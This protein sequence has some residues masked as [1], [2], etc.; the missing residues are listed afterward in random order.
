MG[1]YLDERCA[2]LRIPPL[3]Y[4]NAFLQVR[5]KLRHEVRLDREQDHLARARAF[6]ADEPRVHVPALLPHCT[7][8][9]TAMERLTG[10]LRKT[11]SNAAFLQDLP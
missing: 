1:A 7:P 4:A 6:Y 2:D 11:A 5:D 9:V 3:D 8:R 10:R